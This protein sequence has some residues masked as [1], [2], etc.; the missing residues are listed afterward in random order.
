MSFYIITQEDG[1]LSSKRKEKV[2][3]QYSEVIENYEDL[4]RD[5]TM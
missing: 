3:R 4:R 5:V 2:K 1:D